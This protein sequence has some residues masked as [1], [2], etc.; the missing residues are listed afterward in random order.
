MSD[1]LA[2][3]LQR[4]REEAQKNRRKQEDFLQRF[5]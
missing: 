4:L 2:P 1:I 5:R 3:L